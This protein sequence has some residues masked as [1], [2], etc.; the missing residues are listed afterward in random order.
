MSL[1]INDPL[2]SIIMPVHN[3]AHSISRA[4]NSVITQSFADWELI[5]VDDGSTDKTVQTIGKYLHQDCRIKLLKSKNTGHVIARNLGLKHSI[6]RYLTFIDGNDE[7]LKPHLQLHVEYLVQNK[8]IQIVFSSFERVGDELLANK[9][10]QSQLT[11]VYEMMPSWSAFIKKE[12]LESTGGFAN[13]A[14]TEDTSMV[15]KLIRT[16]AKFRVTDHKTYRYHLTES[17]TLCILKK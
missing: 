17:D 10:D 1:R 2:L 11:F 3:C 16:G 7:Y 5:I 4:V 14:Y 9:T 12:L 15:E 6:G 13:M 8:D